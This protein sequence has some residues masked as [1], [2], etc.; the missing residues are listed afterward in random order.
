MCGHPCPADGV[1]RDRALVLQP[2]GRGIVS[3][4][5]EAELCRQL[6]APAL[7]PHHR[8]DHRGQLAFKRKLSRPR[9]LSH[10]RRG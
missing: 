5:E 1:A 10:Y 4:E 9:R 7:L 6:I 2:T 8:G 3:A